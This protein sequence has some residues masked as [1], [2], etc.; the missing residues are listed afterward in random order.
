MRKG[1]GW[2]GETQRW[3]RT[4]CSWRSAQCEEWAHLKAC[5]FSLKF[6]WWLLFLYLMNHVPTKKQQ[7]REESSWTYWNFAVCPL[8]PYIFELWLLRYFIGGGNSPDFLQI[9]V[10]LPCA[11]ASQSGWNLEPKAVVA[12]GLSPSPSQSPVSVLFLWPA[13]IW[14]VWDQQCATVLTVGAVC[15]LHCCTFLS[16]VPGGLLCGDWGCHKAHRPCDNSVQ[17]PRLHLHP[18]SACPWDS[19]WTYRFVLSALSIT[20]C[21]AWVRNFQNYADEVLGRLVN[22]ACNDKL[23]GL[24][25]FDCNKNIKW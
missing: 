5:I 19:R 2:G 16:H 14:C 25:K 9:L 6:R 8:S 13:S 7:S 4:Q 23:N 1:E 11:F 15:F 20:C 12:P 18:G 22:V 3:G 21:C 17:S 10:P 24:G